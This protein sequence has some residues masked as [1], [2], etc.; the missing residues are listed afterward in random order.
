MNIQEPKRV[1]L[2]SKQVSE[3]ITPMA[4]VSQQHSRTISG[5]F[6][7]VSNLT[8]PLEATQRHEEPFS[9]PKHVYQ[10]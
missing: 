9:D 7:L 6:V 1:K 4:Q 3:N 2:Q 8:P 5:Q 10:T